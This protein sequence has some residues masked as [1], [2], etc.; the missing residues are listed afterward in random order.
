MLISVH[1][2]P[3]FGSRE[4]REEGREEYASRKRADQWWFKFD[5]ARKGCK[6]GSSCVTRPTSLSWKGK[7]RGN[8]SRWGPPE[9]KLKS[10]GKVS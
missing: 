7:G 4:G 6:V 3:Q 9:T 8:Y 2:G 5:C 1:P 10:T